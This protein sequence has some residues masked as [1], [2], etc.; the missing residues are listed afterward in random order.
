[1]ELSEGDRSEVN[2]RHRRVIRLNL[3]ILE[4]TMAEVERLIGAEGEGILRRRRN[5]LSTATRQELLD[6]IEQVRRTLVELKD[7]FGFAVEE[8]DVTRMIRA[9]LSHQWTV[10]CDTESRRLRGYGEPAPELAARLDP[11]IAKL[12]RLVEGMEACLVR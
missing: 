2:L 12:I 1:M 4:E 5:P 3:L 6:R 10:L 9:L 7:S 11:S 8:Q